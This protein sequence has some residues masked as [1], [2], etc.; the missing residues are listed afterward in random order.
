MK[1]DIETATELSILCAAR[2]KDHTKRTSFVDNLLGAQLKRYGTNIVLATSDFGDFPLDLYSRL[3]VEAFDLGKNVITIGF[4]EYD[5]Q[6]A[7]D[8]RKTFRKKTT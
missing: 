1:Q 4:V 3:H 7:E 8:C 2:E 5:R 6:K